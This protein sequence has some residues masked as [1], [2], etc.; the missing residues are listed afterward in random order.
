MDVVI[1]MVAMNRDAEDLAEDHA[2][3][4]TGRYVMP[5][6]PTPTAQ[7]YADSIGRE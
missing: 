3:R 1:N 5:L 6:G 4:P 2:E 7:R